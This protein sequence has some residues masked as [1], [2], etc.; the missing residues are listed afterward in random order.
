MNIFRITDKP[1]K[2]LFLNGRMRSH[3]KYLLERFQ[4][5]G[6]LDQSLWT[7][8]DTDLRLITTLPQQ[9]WQNFND[10]NV[11]KLRFEQD[12]C[13]RMERPIE[14]HFLPKEYEI[15]SLETT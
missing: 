8:L 15:L 13:R 5:N 6:L 1:Y 3:R 7:N 14:L 9:R 12:W 2:F 10:I 11:I 4:A